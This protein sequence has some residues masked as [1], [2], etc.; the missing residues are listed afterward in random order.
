MIIFRLFIAGFIL[1]MLRIGLFP[2]LIPEINQP[3]LILPMIVTVALLIG[4]VEAISVAA[5]FGLLLDLYFRRAFGL[6]LLLFVSIATFLG[7]YREKF[8]HKSMFTVAVITVI[9]GITY[10]VFYWLGLT[11]LGIILKQN[12]LFISL[13][14]LEVPIQVIFSIIFY[15]IF[16]KKRY[17][18]VIY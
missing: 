7:S 1:I 4:K 17:R 13:F 16:S 15:K 5:I 11:F 8:T 14:S 3:E 12:A 6:R 2:A 10:T 18:K 9:C